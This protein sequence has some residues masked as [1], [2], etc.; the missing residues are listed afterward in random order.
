MNLYE[1]YGGFEFWHDCIYGLYLD[2]FDHPEISY[3]FLGVDM[4]ELSKKQAQFLVTHIGGP[5]LYTGPPIEV[6]HRFMGISAFQFDEIAKSFAEV[7][8]DKGVEPEDV[9]HIMAFI[10]SYRDKIV[11]SKRSKI[12]EFMIPIYMTF[13]KYFGRFLGG[14]SS[15][16]RSAKIFNK[17][18]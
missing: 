3:H 13:A 17:I 14:D 18:K 10:G 12:D 15:W 2:M 5:N 16:V 9:D 4:E 11:S 8:L 1:K 6:V 7:F